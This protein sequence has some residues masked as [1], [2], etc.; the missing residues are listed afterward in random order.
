[1]TALGARPGQDEVRKKFSIHPIHKSVLERPEWRLYWP[2]RVQGVFKRSF[3]FGFYFMVVLGTP[4]LGAFAWG[5]NWDEGV[6]DGVTYC[7]LK[8]VYSALVTIVTFPG[9]FF[10]AI[11]SD[12]FE[13]PEYAYLLSNTASET[14]TPAGAS[15]DTTVG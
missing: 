1:M 11:S 2:V 8:G 9:M 14:A 5:L 13:K 15:K 7:T 12:K 6:I 10:S 3:A 4:L